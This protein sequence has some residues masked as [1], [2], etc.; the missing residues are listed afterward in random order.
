MR[1][2]RQRVD[3]GDVRRTSRLLGLQTG[4]LVIGV[5]VVVSALLLVVYQRASARDAEHL[6]GR[7]IST[8]DKASEAP[9][10]VLVAVVTPVGRSV[11]PG[12]PA[13]LPDQK[14]LA[15]VARDHRARQAEL[16][17]HGRDY[18]VRTAAVGD[19]V[20]QAILDRRQS[21]EERE[22]VLTSILLAGG[23]GVVLAGLLAAWLARRAVRPLAETVALQRRFVADA[24]HELRTPL[25]LLS[26]RVQL[27]A[28]RARAR[29]TGTADL[30]GI[31]G[32]TR[33]LTDVLDDL[34]VAADTRAGT[35]REPLDLG[36]LVRECAAAAEASAQ[37]AGLRLDVLMPAG[38]VTVE[39][40]PAALR[41]A[42]TALV[43]NAVGHAQTAV[44]V[45]VEA[46][47]REAT[48]RVVDDGPGISPEVAPRMFE[49]FTSA[50]GE[51]A[52]PA[53]GRRHYGIGLA[54]VADVASAHDGHVTGGARPDGARGAA[55]T[56]VLPVLRPS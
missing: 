44:R 18:L 19:R 29:G 36:V 54:L 30:D 15:A 49:R 7:T 9:P 31:L 8:I 10:D 42:V 52:A 17:L 11:S 46:S 16:T 13:G 2:L 48:V 53:S 24:S 22:R 35:P 50:R 47:G 33:V 55:L 28:R 41:R 45:E 39:G 20:T 1:R 14:M 4:L 51:S 25:T 21:E 26:T 40:V 3:A 12:M 56:L 23:V 5:L 38:P 6:L 37:Q 32:D 27:A 43:D 34:L